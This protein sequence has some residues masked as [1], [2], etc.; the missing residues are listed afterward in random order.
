MLSLIP[1]SSRGVVTRLSP[2]PDFFNSNIFYPYPNSLAFSEILLPQALTS[3]PITFATNNSIFGYNVTLLAMLWL[4]AFAM[5]LLALDMTRSSEAGWV[6]GAIYAFNPFNLS[7]LAQLQLLSLAW[8]PLSI[9]FLRR[10]VSRPAAN[11][12][13]ERHISICYVR[14]FT[15]ALFLLLCTDRGFCNRALPLIL[16]L[17][18]ASQVAGRDAPGGI[19]RCSFCRHNRHFHCSVPSAI[20]YRTARV[21][22]PAGGQGKRTIQRV[23]QAVYGSQLPRMCFLD[24]GSHHSPSFESAVTLSTTFFPVLLP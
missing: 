19:A 12:Q 11:C 6:A 7:N 5:Y 15:G 22:I 8:L 4:N 18:T 20:L 16:A 3:L 14:Y 21:R 10:M 24:A 9:L 17:D 13:M 23:P 1:G 2:R